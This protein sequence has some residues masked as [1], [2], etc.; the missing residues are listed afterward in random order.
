MV[1][2]RYRHFKGAEYIV[3]DIA[4]HTET[5]EIMVI[6]KDLKAPNRTYAIPLE[7]FVSAVDQNKYPDVQQKMSFEKLKKESPHNHNVYQIVADMYNAICKSYPHLTKMSD[8]RKRAIRARLNGAYTLEDFRKVFTLAEESSF[9]KGQ[10]D[11]N[12]SATFDWLISDANMA[13]VLD[14]NY[15]Q[16]P[17]YRSNTGYKTESTEENNKPDY[18]DMLKG[19]SP[20]PDYPFQ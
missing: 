15:S 17:N 9:L 19:C 4:L 18:Y 1:G 11:R 5:N 12:W 13:K 20:Q 10:N 2:Y 8:K 16:K 3:V 6:Y 7:M 14:G